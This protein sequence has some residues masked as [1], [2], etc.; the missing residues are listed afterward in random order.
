M[1]YGFDYGQAGH[2]ALA[3][4]TAASACRIFSN[5]RTITGSVSSRERIRRHRDGSDTYHSRGHGNGHGHGHGHGNGNGHGQ[6]HGQGNGNGH[7]Q[8]HGQGNGNG[9]GQGHGQGNGNAQ[10]LS[11]SS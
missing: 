11:I 8:G 4:L 9:H 2:R 10:V 5:H 3:D 1:V 6:G 7:G